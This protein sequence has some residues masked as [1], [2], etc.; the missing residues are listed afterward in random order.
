MTASIHELVDRWEAKRAEWA[1]LHAQVDGAALAG[2]VLRDLAELEEA[3]PVLSLAE[4]ARRTG[5][6][7]DHLS[8]LVREGA[9][10]NHGR[11]GAPR[12]KLSECPAKPALRKVPGYPYNPTA[13]AR[14]LGIR[15]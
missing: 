12:V 15:R 10:P 2:E 5:Y 14:P 4:A 3:E 9:L 8:R 11:K 1:R 7:P 13:D 6:S